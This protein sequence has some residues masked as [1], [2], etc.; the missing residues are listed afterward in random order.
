[1]VCAI[2][3]I[4]GVI[5]WLS[6]SLL[7][8]W[9]VKEIWQQN[10]APYLEENEI[11][12]PVSMGD[13]I[14]L[15]AAFGGAVVGMIFMSHKKGYSATG[16]LV[17]RILRWLVGIIIMVLIFVAYSS[18][19]ESLETAGRGTLLPL[20]WEAFSSFI[21]LFSIFYPIPLLFCRLGLAKPRK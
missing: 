5:G 10:A 4:L 14:T 18:L 9:Q 2:S 21:F 1:M 16:T 19:A 20:L 12:N 3:V 7:E 11:F 13:V 17:K 6:V 15:I 8:G